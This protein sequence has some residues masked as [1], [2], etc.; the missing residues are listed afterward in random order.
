M[1]YKHVTLSDKNDKKKTTKKQ[2]NTSLT[3]GAAQC[4]NVYTGIC[5]QR[6]PR[7]A[8]ASAPSDQGLRCPDTESL[9]TIE[10]FNGINSGDTLRMRMMI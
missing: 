9:D 10:C 7:S 4:K 5:G 3:K 6:K 2:T 1:F 8:C